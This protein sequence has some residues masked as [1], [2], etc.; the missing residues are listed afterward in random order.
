VESTLR[1]HSGPPYLGPPTAMEATSPYGTHTMIMWHR[2]LTLHRLVAG[3]VLMPS[4]TQGIQLPAV[5]V[6]ISTM[7]PP[8][9]GR[10]KRRNHRETKG[11]LKGKGAKKLRQFV[12]LIC[13][14]FFGYYGDLI[15]GFI[16]FFFLK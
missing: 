8:L 13:A 16:I 7:H 9:L 10:K 6:S 12:T 3:R 5:W 15:L 1:L 11:K 14:L 4:S 2:S